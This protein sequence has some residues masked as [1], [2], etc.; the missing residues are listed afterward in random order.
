MRRFLVVVVLAALGA[1]GWFY[2][3]K[4]SGAQTA[5]SPPQSPATSA[6]KAVATLTRIDGPFAKVVIHGPGG[7]SDAAE[8]AALH[9]GDH[10]VTGISQTAK[11]DL[12][13][14][15]QVVLGPS[16]DLSLDEVLAAGDGH[17]AL[18]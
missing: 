18:S 5:L 7:T 16:S 1:G 11:I 13:D 8:G 17:S 3:H 12:I 6:A 15:S 14:G 10:V 2:V 4:R 9:A